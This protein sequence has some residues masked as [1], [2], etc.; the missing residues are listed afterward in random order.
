MVFSIFLVSVVLYLSCS[1]V[2][3][4]LIFEAPQML[5]CPV[6]IIAMKTIG[7]N[8]HSKHLFYLRTHVILWARAVIC[9]AYEMLPT[10]INKEDFHVGPLCP[11]GCNRAVSESDTVRFIFSA[12]SAVPSQEK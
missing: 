5:S 2:L 3:K 12:P 7:N 4:I 11:H 6:G 1:S 8:L 9:Y 10:G